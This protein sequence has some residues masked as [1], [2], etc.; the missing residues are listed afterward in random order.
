M[1]NRRQIIY[2]MLVATLA[3]LLLIG[4]APTRFLSGDEVILDH[5]KVNTDQPD[6]TSSMLKGYVRQH[7][8]SR[9]FSLLKVPLA[10]YCISGTDSTRR[11]NRFFR[12]IGEAPVVYDSILAQRA[13]EAMTAA[14]RNLGFLTATVDVDANIRKRYATL[15]YNVHA[16]KPYIV[17]MLRRHIADHTIDSILATDTA[18]SLLH[19]GM[20]FDIN[21]LDSERS[22][23]ADVLQDLGYHRFTKSDIRFEADTTLG[24]NRVE[25]TMHIP[26]Y[27]P[28]GMPD[29]LM[30]HP[31]YRLGRIRY[32]TDIDVSALQLDTLHTTIDSVATPD[33]IF[34]FRGKKQLAP[35]FVIAKSKLREGE[36][37][38]DSAIHSTYASLSALS[39]LVGTS[40]A[41]EPD[42][43][44]PELLNANVSLVTARRHG[45]SL[46]VEGTNSAGDFGAAM[47]IGYQN[48]NLF[49][50][51]TMLSLKL[52]GAFE[53]I[54]GL[55]GYADQNYIEYGGEVELHFPEF[56]F[57]FLRRAFRNSSNAQSIASLRYNSQ[58][59]PEFHRRVLTASWRYQW[60]SS[61]G[62]L[63][64]RIDAVD[65]N[66]VF[67]PWISDTFA[68]EYLSDDNSKRN[69]VLRYNYS[70]LFIMRWAYSFNFTNIP[71][72]QQNTTQATNTYS[73][74][75]RVETAGN[76]LNAMSRIFKA[77][78]SNELNAYTLFNIRYAQYA[79]L[80]FDF[81]K[82][83][84][85]DRRNSFAVHAAFGVAVP[86]GNSDVLPY[87]K[88]YFSGGANSVR[89]WA[90]RG[91]GPGSFG[92]SDG[93]VDF[94][95]QTG[96]MKLDLSAEWRT[97]LFWKMDGA[98]FVDAGN[99]WTLRDYPEQPGG[100]FRIDEFWRQIA[101]AYGL[102]LRLNFGYFLVRLD[103]GMKAIDPATP[104]GRNHYPIIHPNFKRDFHLHFAVGLPF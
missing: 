33:G 21:V 25:L 66:Y 99:V 44:N 65:L 15:T 5:V 77:Q 58:D 59:R 68:E 50:R 12:R 23:I 86:Y 37:V 102:G 20:R 104:K 94:I 71:A 79:K 6:V 34:Y 43:T 53:A 19:E 76:L 87:E 51:S 27:R 96:D 64:H 100:Q 91:L 101:V 83:F 70:D 31:R 28:T 18:H 24:Q 7:P 56:V 93:R 22:R 103:A 1:C 54:K 47:S 55:K 84:R 2:D 3:M 97:H 4:C 69:A 42:A 98:A 92:G 82:N 89:G 60:S 14:T 26:L 95:R 88:R 80:D 8:N 74:R 39:A 81:A 63:Q 30:Q 57:P 62:R 67:M 41:V 49:R 75:L 48:R 16:G 35:S 10:V 40:I 90:V 13:C 17:S 29:T 73:I 85:I 78:Y 72:S 11:I 45:V 38:S 9:W 46:D 36:L 61:E 32:L 52:R